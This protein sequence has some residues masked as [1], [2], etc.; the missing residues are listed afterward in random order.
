MSAGGTALEAEADLT[1]EDH[2]C[3]AGRST[4]GA[5]GVPGMRVV[6][7]VPVRVGRHRLILQSVDHAA[8]PLGAAHRFGAGYSG[9]AWMLSG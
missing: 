8:P 6:H 7:A 4:S 9:Q 3:G 1:V 5:L 2:F